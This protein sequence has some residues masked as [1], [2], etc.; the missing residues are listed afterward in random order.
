MKFKKLPLSFVI[1]LLFLLSL[2]F[3]SEE[4]KL[5]SEEANAGVNL[6][7]SFEDCCALQVGFTP[8]RFLVAIKLG[9]SK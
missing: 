3:G 7:I 6:L 1:G 5:L 9:G 8:K 4:Y 2:I